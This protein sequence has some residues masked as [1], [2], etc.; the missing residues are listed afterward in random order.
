MSKTANS[1]DNMQ[2]LRYGFCFACDRFIATSPKCPYCGERAVLP[3]SLL[4]LRR[5]AWCIALFGLLFLWI[6]TR[7]HIP[8]RVFAADVSSEMN[9]ARIQ[10]KGCLVRTP[11]IRKENNRVRYVSFL[12][13]DNTGT[14]RVILRNDVAENA[15]IPQK[16]EFVKVTGTV[17]SRAGREHRLTLSSPEGLQPLTPAHK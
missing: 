12:L 17:T 10:I 8:E 1:I 2:N 7:N 9:Y 5:S 14:V 4:W 11:Y 15:Y 13:N 16:G 6:A 3:K